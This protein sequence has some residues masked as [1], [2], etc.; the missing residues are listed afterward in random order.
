MFPRTHPAMTEARKQKTIGHVMKGLVRFL[1]F[2]QLIS[3]G[4]LW[5]MDGL[6]LGFKS[7]TETITSLSITNG[8][9][10]RVNT[11]I[12]TYDLCDGIHGTAR[13]T[14]KVSAQYLFITPLLMAHVCPSSRL[15][16]CFS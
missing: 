6:K 3:I 12:T 16:A 14:W 11:T 7:K 15:S 4:F 2:L 1:V 13:R 10:G 9:C 5:T 8:T